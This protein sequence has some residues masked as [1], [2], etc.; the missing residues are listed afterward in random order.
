MM[1]DHWKS[2][3]NRLGAPG[4]D[5]PEEDTQVE[6]RVETQAEQAPRSHTASVQHSAPKSTPASSSKTIKSTGP[7][8][9]TPSTAGTPSKRD[10]FEPSADAAQHESFQESS[11]PEPS[12][13]KPASGLH[14]D[15]SQ[16]IPD[17]A[18]SF[19]SLRPKS[20]QSKSPRQPEPT[21]PTPT[22]TTPAA[23][24][25][26]EPSPLQPA[27]ARREA[28]RMQDRIEA[29]AP[30][31]PPPPEA[32]PRRKS[33][34]E[35]LANMFNIKVDRSKPAEAVPEVEAPAPQPVQP[36]GSRPAA[37]ASTEEDQPFSIFAEDRPSRSNPALDAMFGDAP[38]PTKS[39][40]DDWGKPRVIDDLGWEDDGRKHT[41]QR[42]ESSPSSAA[43]GDDQRRLAS[44][45][46]ASDSDDEEA[47][48]RGRR[49]RRGRRGRSDSADASPAAESPRSWGG[50]DDDANGTADDETDHGLHD[51]PWEEPESFE[52]VQPSS[53]DQ[54][55]FDS[56]GAAEELSA[57]GEVLRRSS[58]HRRRG[59]RGGSGRERDTAETPRGTPAARSPGRARPSPSG[60][61]SSDV[62]DGPTG[63]RDAD[64]HDDARDQLDSPRAATG[65]K[66]AESEDSGDDRGSRSRRRSGSGDRAPSSRREPAA[67]SP[68]RTSAPRRPARPFDDEG[69]IEDSFDD[70]SLGPDGD[71]GEAPSGEG[72]HRS[73]PTWADS[74]ASLIQTN[75]EN[76]KRG[77][78]RGAPRGRPRGRR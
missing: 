5:E 40:H 53:L 18:L 63:F 25:S 3:A 76:R 72:Q 52:L 42:N 2:I 62:S 57:D 33:S 64:S 51:D 16:P 19:K 65:P 75:T 23:R 58:R 68:S 77:D 60:R 28:P 31:A 1:A 11:S 4:V 55:D 13:D 66:R 67:D 32:P 37:E 45:E 15:P 20:S 9:E 36:R 39:S 7:R 74:I 10:A 24:S 22:P 73:I 49:R 54:T 12:G 38:S 14:F 43:E 47:P 78:N 70:A 21:P 48:R 17:E 27:Q 56:D 59:G 46:A 69:P 35:S 6:T 50:L 61:S 30:A 8:A 34:W 29:E 41:S 44:P 26:S 71:E